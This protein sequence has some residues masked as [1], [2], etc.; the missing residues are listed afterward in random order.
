VVTREVR[1]LAG[2]GVSG[3][4]DGRGELAS[5]Y[6]PQSVAVHEDET[7][8][9][10]AE[11]S[12]RVRAMLTAYEPAATSMSSGRRLSEDPAVL[13]NLTNGTANVTYVNRNPFST[14]VTTIVDDRGPAD[15]LTEVSG[16]VFAYGWPGGALM[17]S[18]SRK[19]RIYRFALGFA[20]EAADATASDDARRTR[21]QLR[22]LSEAGGGGGLSL[23][24]LLQLNLTNA[25]LAAELA[26]CG[27]N[28]TVPLAALAS[29]QEFALNGTGLGSNATNSSLAEQL[30]LNCSEHAGGDGSGAGGDG[31]DTS[32][33]EQILAA[34]DICP[35]GVEPTA[36]SGEICHPTL[37]LLAGSTP[38]MLDG[39]NTRTRFYRPR[40]LSIDPT[41]RHVYIADAYN[42]RVRLLALED[43]M[44]VDE[45][46][47]E[48]PIDRMG[49][50]LR[51][52][53][54]FILSLVG[55]SLGLTC[56]TW[57]CCR[58]CSLCPVYQRKLHEKRL[59]TMHM[60]TRA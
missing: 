41:T 17:L 18:E 52:N 16:V 27:P 10:V 32:M 7:T 31:E 37:R 30:G 48:T 1:T 21:R 54:V 2:S 12:P 35:Q 20:T 9:Y 39:M 55:G 25:T 58:Y 5:F 47:D 8:V 6:L 60:G 46:E 45:Q 38:G 40:G 43:V 23:E 22:R 29:L 50:A 14:S 24:E 3:Q 11:R 51:Q 34:T 42:H 49:R 28:V 57:T 15:G 53:F 19:H 26:L 59:R 13:F 4:A 36:A 44:T 56:L 33:E